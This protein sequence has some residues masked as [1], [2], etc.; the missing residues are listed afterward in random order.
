[1]PTLRDLADRIRHEIEIVDLIGAHV[2]LRPR[3]GR[4]VG[5]CPFHDDHRP[6]FHVDP[7]RGLY[8][9]FSCKAGGD[10]IR[11]VERI[12]GLDFKGALELL[13]QQMGIP[14]EMYRGV[15]REAAEKGKRREETLL[16]ASRLARDFFRS[17]LRDQR[18]GRAAQ[19]YLDRRAIAPQLID[20]F[21]I[22]LAPP[23]WDGLLSHLRAKGFRPQ[24]AVEA[25][26]AVHHQERDSDYD[27]FRGRLIFP[28]WD[29][30]GRPVAFGGRVLDDGDEGT[31]KYINSPESPIYRKGEVVYAY[32]LAREAI[33]ERGRAVLCEGYLDVIAAHG[34]DVPEAVAS[35]G[36]ALTESQAKL[37]R[38]L[39]ERVV[40]LYDADAAGRSAT[41]RGCEVLLRHGLKVFIAPLET[42]L[43]PDDVVRLNGPRALRE[44][45]DNAQPALQFLAEW[46]LNSGDGPAEPLERRI[47]VLESL[48]PC[49]RANSNEISRDHEIGKVA[50]W[51][52]IEEDLVRRHLA[53][54]GPGAARDLQ[55]DLQQR[56]LDRPPVAEQALLRCLLERPEL[57]DRVPQREVL[58][59]VTHAGIRRWIQRLLDVPRPPEEGERCAAPVA[60]WL[61]LA[62]GD[63]EVLLREILM[64][65][66]DY[67]DPERLL[68]Y[69]LSRLEREAAR[70]RLIGTCQEFG[71]APDAESAG[72]T[73]REI[74]ELGSQIFPETRNPM[75]APNP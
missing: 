19:A 45:V 38:R 58:D 23:G 33:R 6:S 10:A 50:Q 73:A 65:E 2:E 59:W 37:L 72:K 40:F 3:G 18:A 30:L 17:T 25:G 66:E 12:E 14:F 34:A 26:L 52:G 31:P 68:A 62:D 8:H 47:W 24:T 71:A 41:L 67:S 9:C 74:H 22:G 43:D 57:G 32:H 49:L 27:R 16:E 36:T 13:A 70:R 7:S 55:Q 42:G 54:P 44:L 64:A 20:R 48:G 29:A 56:K 69:T 11:F 5:L 4:F 53:R 1:M 51:V 75:R 28:I 39:A 60:E 35:L 61:A 46:L 15:P 21:E 63:D